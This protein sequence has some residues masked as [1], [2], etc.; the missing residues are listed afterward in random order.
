M[1]GSIASGDDPAK[2]SGVG[3][4]RNSAGVALLTPTSVACA[5]RIVAI[6][7]SWAEAKSSSQRASGWSSSSAA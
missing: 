4:A 1:W 7:S 2:A 3:N 5:L 6:S